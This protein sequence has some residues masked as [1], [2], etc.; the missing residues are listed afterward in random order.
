MLIQQI[1][2]TSILL[3]LLAGLLCL[4]KLP[5]M[6]SLLVIG[7]GIVLSVASLMLLQAGPFSFSPQSVLGMNPDL[8]IGIL[9]FALLLLILYVSYKLKSNKLIILSLLQIVPLAFL[10]LF[11]H[12]GGENPAPTIFADHLTLIMVMVVSIIGSL[13]CIYGLSYMKAHERHLG[14][15]HSRQGEFF[16]LMLLFLGAMN[17]LVLSNNLLWVYFFW[18]VTTFCSFMLIRHDRTEA[19]RAN[20]ERALWMNML[21]GVGFVFALVILRAKGLPLFLQELVATSPGAGLSLLPLGLLCFAGFTKAAQIPFQSWLCGAMVAPTP[22]SALLHSSTMVK[23]GVYLILRL[24]PA[25]AGTLFSSYVALFGAFTFIAT[26]ILALSQ[27]NGK[28]ILAYSTIGNLGMIIACAGINT[29][30]AISAA[31]LLIIF[32]A[33]SKGLLFLCVGTIEQKIGSRDIE[34]MRGLVGTMPWT[35]VIALIGMVTMF[36][37]PFGALLCKWMAIEAASELPL[38]IVMLALGSALTVVF[39][40]RWAGILLSST[41]TE[42]KGFKEEQDLLIRIPL[43]VLAVLA[44][45]ISFGIPGVYS[46]MVLPVVRQYCEIASHVA[47]E[48][49]LSSQPEA[50]FIYPLFLIMGAGVLWACRSSRKARKRSYCPPYMSGLESGDPDK[51]GFV[52]PLRQWADFKATN[53]YLKAFIGEKKISHSINMISIGILIVL[54]AGVL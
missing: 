37:P 41:W 15:A 4:L 43:A 21:G 39:W 36:L 27:S 23:A 10:E 32:H 9:D 7:T 13:I 16:F 30:A 3:P 35:A 48:G 42:K 51:I 19:A 52:G 22:V 49:F 46:S 26:S 38:V 2:G 28:K 31:I 47:S 54:L 24:A 11:M 40:T 33:V 8:L 20:A 34:D 1:A 17:G 5:S 12:P 6:R 44:V 14:L 29:P 18:E 25:F 45:M 53:Y 50:F